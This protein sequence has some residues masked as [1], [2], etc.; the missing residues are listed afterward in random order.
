MEASDYLLHIAMK[1]VLAEKRQR[2]ST[3][4]NSCKAFYSSRGEGRE[5]RIDE[6]IVNYTSFL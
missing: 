6:N 5:V 3:P 1:Q 4:M 2:Q